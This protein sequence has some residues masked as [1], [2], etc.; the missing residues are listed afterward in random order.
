LCFCYY[1]IFLI[2]IKIVLISLSSRFSIFFEVQK[3][4]GNRE[5]K[6]IYCCSF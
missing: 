6:W 3:K 1:F 2:K 5:K 4:S